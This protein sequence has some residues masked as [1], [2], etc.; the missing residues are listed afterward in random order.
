M[1]IFKKRNLI[2][3]SILIVTFLTYI[4]SLSML[5]IRVNGISKN[6]FKKTIVLDA[7]HGGIDGGVI[8]ATTGV[9]E[10]E[11][12]LIFV[13]KL[14]QIFV[15]AGF[16]VVLTRNTDAGLYGIATSSRKR[17]DML[18]R[19]EII[20]KAEPDAVI[21]IHMNNYS[22]SS[23]RGA[24]VFY[25]SKLNESKMLAESVQNCFNNMPEASRKCE[26]LKGN[27]YIL[28]CSNFPSVICECGFLSNKEDELLLLS[29]E[30]QDKICYAIFSGVIN[31]FTIN[32]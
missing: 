28:E 2:I 25:N 32:N 5:N 1:L 22:L 3:I 30:Y 29:K 31:F 20:L 21:S 7:G 17:R 12:N 13:R 16:N 10:S 9:K 11:L 18:K 19:K 27:Y 8:G 15:D 4:F 14:E 26:S 23:R 24:Q 6:G